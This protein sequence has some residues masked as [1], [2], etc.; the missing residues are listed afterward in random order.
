[1]NVPVVS[2]GEIFKLGLAIGLLA[3]MLVERGFMAIE[4]WLDKRAERYNK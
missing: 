2:A 1:M 4:R 3:G